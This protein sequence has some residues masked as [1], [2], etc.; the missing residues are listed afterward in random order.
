MV[1]VLKVCKSEIVKSIKK[2]NYATEIFL[3]KSV[4]CDDN[5]WVVKATEII[6]NYK[7]LIFLVVI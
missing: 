1:F 4:T 2:T 3:R 7:K 5:I 6:G